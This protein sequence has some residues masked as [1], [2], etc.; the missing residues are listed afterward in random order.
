MIAAGRSGIKLAEQQYWP[1]VKA[2]VAYGFRNGRS[3]DTKRRPDFITARLSFDLPVFTKNRQD[4]QLNASQ[5]RYEA[6]SENKASD[7]RQLVEMLNSEYTKW[8]QEQKSYRL[9]QK[10]LLPESKQYAQAT[11]IAYQN[12]QTDFPTLA[13]AYIK[14]F[15][16]Q[17][18]Y[19]K[20]TINREKARVNLLYLEGK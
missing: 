2:G 17:T 20:V 9:Y 6:S 11:L 8:Q 7:Y 3:L 12:A 18:A 13:R 4:R 16:T 1:G 14:Q 19:L 15:T 10:T 5:K